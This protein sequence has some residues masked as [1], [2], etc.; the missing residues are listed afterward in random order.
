MPY[1]LSEWRGRIQRAVHEYEVAREALDRLKSQAVADASAVHSSLSEHLPQAE[2][3]LEGTY[4]IR[5]FAVFDAA[6]RSYDRYHFKD[7]DRDAKVAVMINQLGALRRVAR[8]IREG[9]H[10]VRRVRHFRAHELEED[11]GPMSLD[12]VRGFLQSYLDRI[13][14]N[15]S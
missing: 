15:W 12:R 13:P 5:V 1:L 10:R 7:Q 3:N 9:V 8:P 11:P 14:K 6:L 2:L 4:I